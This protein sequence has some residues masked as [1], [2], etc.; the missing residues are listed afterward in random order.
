MRG[1]TIALNTALWAAAHAADQSMSDAST[2]IAMS[3][4]WTIVES[5]C[6]SD[7]VYGIRALDHHAENWDASCATIEDCL[8]ACAAE[9]YCLAGL[10]YGRECWC[11]NVVHGKAR[12]VPNGYCNHPCSGDYGQTCGGFGYM[13][14]YIQ[15]GH[16]LVIDSG[17]CHHGRCG[18][19][20]PWD[21]V[22]S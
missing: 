19:R 2:A 13:N 10:E 22:A 8:V 4:E 15:R 17:D 7:T 12:P 11:G 3:R 6:W 5:H 16:R 20:S 1:A 9:G 21:L 14:M 18:G